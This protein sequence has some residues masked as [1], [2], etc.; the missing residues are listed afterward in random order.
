MPVMWYY[1]CPLLGRHNR[2]GRPGIGLVINLAEEF[3]Q[4]LQ[5][6]PVKA[7]SA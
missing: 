7:S 6:C 2:F 1:G 4:L 5:R 3:P